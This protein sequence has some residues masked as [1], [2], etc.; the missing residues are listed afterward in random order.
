MSHE[1]TRPVMRTIIIE[2]YAWNDFTVRE[3]DRYS[4]R[5]MWDE[6]LGQIVTLTHDEIKNPR[7]PMLTADENQALAA[8]HEKIMNL[9]R[10]TPGW[11]DMVYPNGKP[12]FAS[13]GTMLDED[14]NRSIFDDVDE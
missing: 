6:A 7:F 13:D 11:R 10:H 12:K 14:G 4:E 1:D 3:G 8:R 5:L 9:N 2:Q